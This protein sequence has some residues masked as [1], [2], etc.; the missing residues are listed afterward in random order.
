[1]FV[2]C[3]KPHGCVGIRQ[4]RVF[5][6]VP[7]GHT[8]LGE[9]LR[10]EEKQPLTSDWVQATGSRGNKDG[11]YLHKAQNTSEWSLLLFEI[12]KQQPALPA[13]LISSQSVT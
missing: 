13:E 9:E 5:S 10:R 1:M 4:L 7:I 3:G 6:L 11:A 12:E 8:W 2:L